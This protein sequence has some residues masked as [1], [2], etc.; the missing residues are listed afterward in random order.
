M[1]PENQFR[2]GMDTPVPESCSAC[3]EEGGVTLTIRR[4]QFRYGEGES[5]VEL[6]VNVPVHDCSRCGLSYTAAEAEDIRHAAI[7]KHLGRLTPSEIRAIRR[8]HGASQE[9][10]SEA[11]GIGVAS[12]ARWET[13]A[14][15]QSEGYDRYLRLLGDPA[16]YERVQWKQKAA[17]GQPERYEG[18]RNFP[19]VEEP[20][21]ARARQ[22]SFSLLR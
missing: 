11:S 15:I 18:P 3:G 20:A 14:V 5:A 19:S 10:F 17:S 13:A 6:S 2:S 22:Q 4:Q 1:T 16:N 8:I 21:Q 12:L 7:C 9:Q